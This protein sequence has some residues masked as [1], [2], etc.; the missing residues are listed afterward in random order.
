MTRFLM[1]AILNWAVGMVI[2]LMTGL[3]SLSY[4]Y[5]KYKVSEDEAKII[6]HK[7][8]SSGAHGD[9]TARWPMWIQLT[10][11]ILIWPLW[12]PARAKNLHESVIHELYLIRK[13]KWREQIE[14]A[15]KALHEA[16][17][18]YTERHKSP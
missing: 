9:F 5:I 11:G 15:M 6:V 14:Q 18:S 4:V 1:Y 2:V 7:M 8:H 17:K 16:V 10:V 13:E 3:V 12:L